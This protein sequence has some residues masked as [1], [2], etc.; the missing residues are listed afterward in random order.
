MKAS[1]DGIKE[2]EKDIADATDINEDEVIVH[3]QTSPIKGYHVTRDDPELHEILLIKM[4]NGETHRLGE[5]SPL[6]IE[7]QTIRRLYVFCDGDLELR[8]N[9]QKKCEDIFGCNSDYIPK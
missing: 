2:F 3:V 4:D 5:E 9:V 8:K 7:Y 1:F 6:T